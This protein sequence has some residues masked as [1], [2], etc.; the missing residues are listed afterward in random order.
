MASAGKPAEQSDCA[1][2]ATPSPY[3]TGDP[4]ELALVVA[5]LGV[6]G[7]TRSALGTGKRIRGHG[8]GEVGLIRHADPRCDRRGGAPPGVHRNQ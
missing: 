7:R 8:V 6:K 5:D 1:L 3:S 4:V 2:R